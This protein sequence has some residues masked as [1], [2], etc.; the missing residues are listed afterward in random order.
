MG[1]QQATCQSST[2]KHAPVLNKGTQ[3]IGFSASLSSARAD[4]VV[5]K[6]ETLGQS[7]IAT[8]WIA[9]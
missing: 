9:C 3:F 7:M 6:P 4:R 1:C 5:S 2:G 8:C